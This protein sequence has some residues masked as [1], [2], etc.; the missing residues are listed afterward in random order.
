M[1]NKLERFF[2]KIGFN[3][4][5]DFKD[6]KVRDSN[7]NLLEVYHGTPYNFNT[8]DYQKLGENTS[9]LGA[10]FYFTDSEQTGNEYTRG[11]GE[12]KKVYLDIQKPMS[13][14]KTTMTKGEYQSFI[15]SI[16][17]ETN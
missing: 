7:G 4:I 1:D 8:F 2:N 14:G 17:S 15:E 5:D 11:D 9:S 3:E 10:G 6:S 13:Y 16:N 12:L